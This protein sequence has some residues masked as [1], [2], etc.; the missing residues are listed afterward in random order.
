MRK[1]RGIL[2]KGVERR[3]GILDKKNSGTRVISV[4]A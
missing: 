3:Q 4:V 1:D 2:E